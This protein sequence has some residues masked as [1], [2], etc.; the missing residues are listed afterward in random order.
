MLVFNSPIEL[1]GNTPLLEL[2]KIREKYNLKAKI[3]AKLEFYNPAGG[4]KDRIA[5]QMIEDAEYEGKIKKNTIIIEPT[6]GNTGLGLALICGQKG[7]EFVAI[8]LDKV[9]DTKK[10][11]LK[12]YGAKLIVVPSNVSINDVRSYYN[13]ALATAKLIAKNNGNKLDEIL[14]YIQKLI[15]NS[16]IEKL[17]E[18]LEYQIDY[19]KY[20]FI[21]SQHFNSSNPKAHYLT[22]GKEIWEQT[23]GKITHLIAG[24]GTGGTISGAAKYLKEKN[25]EIKVIG[26]DPKGSLINRVFLKIF[27]DESFE[28]EK[29]II[30]TKSENLDKIEIKENGNFFVVNN[31]FYISKKEIHQYEIEGIGE[32]F[33]PKTL[34][35][36]LIDGIYVVDDSEAFN[37]LKENCK[38]LGFIPGLSGSAAI[39]SAIQISKK[40][41]ENHL[42]VVIVPDDGK[43]YL[44]KIKNIL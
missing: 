16:E 29:F 6:S 33:I 43:K 32:D 18:I 2:K 22:T 9:D 40:L 36:N 35:L 13:V 5:K 3:F 26:V 27:S 11:L 34:N 37:F 15:D 14:S 8:V 25:P 23:N 7:Y 21:P 39:F 1:I 28:K 12:L 24:I 17:K 42:V 31:K 4:V 38:Y 44:N 10:N 30:R 19:N 41:S 20:V